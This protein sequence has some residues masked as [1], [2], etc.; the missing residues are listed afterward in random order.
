MA[1]HWIIS[2]MNPIRYNAP[3]HPLRHTW[4][5]RSYSEQFY[6]PVKNRRIRESLQKIARET[7]EDYQSLIEI[8]QG[9]DIRVNR[10]FI[11][12]DLTILNF[13]DHDGHVSY[14]TAQSFTLI[15]KPPMQPRDSL[16]VVGDRL[17]GT[18]DEAS[19][20]YK[21]CNRSD[22]QFDAPL[23]TV[24]GDHIIVDCRE[25]AWLASYMTAQFPD[26]RVVPVM[27]GGHNDAVFCPV[28]PGL[29]ISTYH[30]SNYCDTFPGWQVKF[31]E[32]QSWNAIP[33]WRQRKHSN[34]DKWWIP[35]A[36]NNPEFAQFVDL[37]L[38]HWLGHVQETVFDVNMLPINQNTV[39]VNNY[40]K[41]MFDFF[42]DKGIE[43]IV[44]SFRHRFF[45]D[46]GI[47]CITG[48]I[49][50]E[51]EAENYVTSR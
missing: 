19:W 2:G 36:D 15:P 5:G 17:L 26:R 29:I 35:D 37:W 16:L 46:G 43:P 48:D 30:H 20:Y 21:H 28:Q 42:R 23:V 39:L 1:N 12:P 6:E 50:R 10:P 32:N 24:I 41:G 45:W 27:I 49:Y 51:G 25:H 14:D 18:S 4:V 11:D 33:A 40:N 22:L 7:E 3:W 31:I 47:H 38:D 13:I 8:L 34:V 9:F 44:S